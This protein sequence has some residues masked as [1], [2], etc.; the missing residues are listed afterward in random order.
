MKT[1]T[2]IC[3]LAIVLFLATLITAAGASAA[4]SP[5][6]V[7]TASSKLTLTG[8]VVSTTA[9]S[10]VVRTDAGDE[11][12]ALSAKTSQ[13]AGLKAGDRV[14]VD[15]TRGAQG[16]RIATRVRP[17]AAAGPDARAAAATPPAMSG[18]DVMAHAAGNDSPQGAPATPA[19]GATG[20]ARH[21]SGD[22]L[23]GELVSLHKATL[24][25]RTAAGQETIGRTSQTVLPK[26]LKTGDRVVVDLARDARG[27]RVATGVRLQEKGDASL[28]A[29]EAKPPQP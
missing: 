21:Q 10:L 17:L 1:R 8:E 28:P 9:T 22:N 5:A 12:L 16:A 20:P 26:D 23:T 7:K 4:S 25:V 3:T 24:V 15:F 19:A 2:Q 14:V 6:G 27:K 18:A 11:T 13:S 29:A